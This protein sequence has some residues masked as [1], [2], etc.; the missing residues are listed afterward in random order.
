MR[1]RDG[2][3][4]DIPK[5]M[6]RVGP[7]PLLWHVMRLLRPFRTH[8]LVLCLGYGGHHIKDFFLDYRE[9]AYNDF[10]LSNGRV[11][12]LSVGHLGL[13]DRLRPRRDG[14]ARSASACAAC[15]HLLDGEDMYLANYADVLTDAPLDDMV[16]RFAG[17]E[18]TASMMVVPPQ[19]SFHC[20]ELGEHGTATGIAPVSQLPLWENGGYFVLGRRSSTTCRRGRRPGRGRVRRP[21]QARPAAGLSVPRLLAAGRHREGTSRAG[22]GV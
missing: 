2:A 21:G 17:S 16:D 4:D 3:A 14:G 10:V 15:E 13:D 19:S 11:D 18:A 5:P 12:L 1:M 7:R 9:T 6:Q 8:G 20:V 22:A